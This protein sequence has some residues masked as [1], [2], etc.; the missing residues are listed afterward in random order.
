MG[1][2]KE[3]D[4]HA[5][6][7]QRSKAGEQG[8][9]GQISQGCVQAGGSEQEALH[10][11]DQHVSGS[12]APAR[13]PWVGPCLTGGGRSSHRRSDKGTPSGSGLEGES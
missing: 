12:V 6:R 1:V 2:A 11:G 10:S 7:R 5:L 4:I 3:M 9:Q 13:L 8:L